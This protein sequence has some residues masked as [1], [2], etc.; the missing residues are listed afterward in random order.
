[1]FLCHVPSNFRPY[2]TLARYIFPGLGS[3]TTSLSGDSEKGEDWGIYR[4]GRPLGQC[5]GH[6]WFPYIVFAGL[7]NVLQRR[8]K[9]EQK[10]VQKRQKSELIETGCLIQGLGLLALITGFSFGL[11][12]PGFIVFFILLVIGHEKA[13]DTSRVS[14]Q[15]SKRGGRCPKCQSPQVTKTFSGGSGKHGAIGAI[16]LGGWHSSGAIGVMMYDHRISLWAGV[17]LLLGLGLIVLG[18]TG[19]FT[20]KY[21]CTRCGKT[22]SGVSQG[23]ACPMCQSSLVQKIFWGSV[24][25]KNAMGVM[26]LGFLFIINLQFGGFPFGS[27]ECFL[28][29]V[30]LFILEMCGSSIPQYK[31]PRCGETF[32]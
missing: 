15:I 12:I 11:F 19:L 8:E 6:P 31:C 23:D 9:M 16:I 22:F 30:V 26:I 13:R 20:P 17:W 29:G 32:S 28:V 5:G 2:G 1:M 18:I 10:R 27:G 7:T 21:R 4:V 25:R 14:P 24:G 3:V